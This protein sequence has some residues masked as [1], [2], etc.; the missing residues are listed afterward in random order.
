MFVPTWTHV[1][2]DLKYVGLSLQDDITNGQIRREIV[3]QNH[4]STNLYTS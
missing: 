1:A 2:L 4:F 3:R